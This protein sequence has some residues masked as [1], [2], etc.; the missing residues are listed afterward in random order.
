[1]EDSIEESIYVAVQKRYEGKMY[2]VKSMA[3]IVILHSCHCNF[4]PLNLPNVLHGTPFVFEQRIT[5][6][7]LYQ[8]LSRFINP[9]IGRKILVTSV[10]HQQ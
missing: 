9:I 8:N 6:P 10:A 7:E 5:K 2:L 1:M 4:S 3:D